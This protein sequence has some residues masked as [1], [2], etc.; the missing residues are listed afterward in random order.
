MDC[1]ATA[2]DSMLRSERAA[3]ATNLQPLQHGS[4]LDCSTVPQF[5]PELQR[6]AVHMEM[7]GTLNNNRLLRHALAR[8]QHTEYMHKTLKD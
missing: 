4:T 3:S 1:S 6:G 2:T 8:R 5:D 7:A